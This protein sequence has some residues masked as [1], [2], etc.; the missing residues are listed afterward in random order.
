MTA[1]SIQRDERV[2]ETQEGRAALPFGVDESVEGPGVAAGLQELGGVQA[3]S[4]GGTLKSAQGALPTGKSKRWRS[5]F[6][7]LLTLSAAEAALPL[8]NG[9]WTHVPPLAAD[10]P[11]SWLGRRSGQSTS[12]SRCPRG[13][14]AHHVEKQ[15]GALV[16]TL[17]PL[18]RS[19]SPS[20]GGLRASQRPQQRRRAS[21]RALC[22]VTRKSA[23]PTGPATRRTAGRRSASS[24]A[25]LR[26]R[27][28]HLVPLC[29][30]SAPPARCAC[31]ARC[32]GGR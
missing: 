9:A 15:T 17:S 7:S 2:G 11:R 8:P 26:R 19:G 10:A 13:R 29:R 4:N 28:A 20:S 18:P 27:R 5:R 32:R 22:R 3:V 14:S 31:S 21:L 24:P 6:A 1:T 16:A 30:S 25:R 12:A 23:L